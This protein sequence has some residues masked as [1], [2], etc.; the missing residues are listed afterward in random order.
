MGKIR[1]QEEE[2]NVM[3]QNAN[4]YDTEEMSISAMKMRR[5][6]V[7]MREPQINE[8]NRKVVDDERRRRKNVTFKE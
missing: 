1:Q 4:Y 8:N 2:A 3:V 5:M 6:D 7:I